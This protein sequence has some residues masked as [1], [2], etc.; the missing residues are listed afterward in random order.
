MTRKEYIVYWK[1]F[2]AAGGGMGAL[3]A[4]HDRQIVCH[5]LCC[6]GKSCRAVPRK[7]NLSCRPGQSCRPFPFLCEMGPHEAQREAAAG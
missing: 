2:P 1:S 7:T 3:R 4:L 6:P 5:G